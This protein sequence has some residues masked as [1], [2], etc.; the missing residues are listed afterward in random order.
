MI[1]ISVLKRL[2]N[3]RVLLVEDD[4]D[5][6][7]AIKQSL[8]ICCKSV[9]WCKNGFEGFEKF[10]KESFDV[11]ISDINMSGISGI[12]MINL[13]KQKAPHIKFIIITAYDNTSNFINSIELGTHSYLRKPFRIEELQT[14]LLTATRHISEILKISENFSYD[15]SQKLLYKDEKIIELTK[16]ENALFELLVKNANKIISYDMIENFVWQ[17]K[18]MSSDALRVCIKKIRQKI[19]PLKIE[20]ISG[21]GYRL[22]LNS[23]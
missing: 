22:I 4:L 3:I 2:N 9:V 14:A 16:H 17:D 13:I 21:S 6:A 23:L 5:S 1:D 12:E 10:Q 8:E 20:N 15:F 7:E 19:A 11:V 18:S